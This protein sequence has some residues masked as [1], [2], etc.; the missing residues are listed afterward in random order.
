[1]RPKPQNP[2]PPRLSP[3]ETA[4]IHGPYAALCEAYCGVYAAW[5]WEGVGDM[6]AADVVVTR[7]S[8]VPLNLVVGA[9]KRHAKSAVTRWCKQRLRKEIEGRPGQSTVNAHVQRALTSPSLAWEALCLALTGTCLISRGKLTYRV[10][11]T[12]RTPVHQLPRR[13]LYG[14]KTAR[15]AARWAV[16]ANKQMI[17]EFEQC[18]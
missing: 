11:G 5:H 12:D 16:K 17:E 8:A 3:M 13:V 9:S 10:R 6:H 4:D 15:A 1:M 18:E 7:T 14:F 2:H